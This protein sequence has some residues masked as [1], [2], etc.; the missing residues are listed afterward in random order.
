MQLEPDCT[1]SRGFTLQLRQKQKARLCKHTQSC[2]GQQISIYLF[3]YLFIYLCMYLL[4][5]QKHR[6]DTPERCGKL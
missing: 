4:H 6:K 5:M 1:G 3:I 2:S